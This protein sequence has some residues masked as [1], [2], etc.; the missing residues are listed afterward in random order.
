MHAKKEATPVVGLRNLTVVLISILLTLSAFAQES[1]V[2]GNLA[3]VATDKTGAVVPGVK[4]NISGPTG[5]KSVQTDSQ[6]RFSFPL[7]VPGFYD[8]ATEKAGFRSAQ[9]K[10]LEVLAGRTAEVNVPVEVGVSTEVIEVHADTTAIDTTSSAV[11]SNLTDEFYSKVPISRGVASLFYTAPGVADGGGTGNANPSISGSSG[12]ENQ[13]VAD[14]VNITNSAYGGLGVY[15]QN[16]GA[17]G[18]GITLS[19]IKEVDVKTGGFEPQYGQ[20]TGGI[21]QII[22]K[23]GSEQYHGALSLYGAPTWGRATA[24][25]RDD[26]AVSK[27]GK[28]VDYGQYELSGELGGFVPGLKEH[29]FFFGSFDPSY[30]HNFWNAPPGAGIFGTQEQ[31]T[32]AYDYAGKLTFKIN[33]RHTIEGSVSGDPAHTGTGQLT[34]P[35][36]L[37]VAN[38]TGFSKWDYGTRNTVARYNGTLSNTWLVNA[39]YGYNIN[40]FHEQPLFDVFNIVD[41][42]TP[43]VTT[44]Q[45][46]GRLEQHEADGSRLT[47]DTSKVVSHWGSHTFSVGYQWENPHYDDGQNRS[48]GT[49]TVPDTN[50]M[51][52][53]Y[54]PSSNPPAA[55]AP[56]DAQFQLQQLPMDSSGNIITGCAI[57]PTYAP[58]G[59]AQVV[60]V[61][62]RGQFGGSGL[63]ATRGLYQ[64]AYVN[65]NWTI[66]RRIS[67]SVG[68][69][70]EQQRVTGTLTHYSFTDNWE[71]RL[72]FSIDPWGNKKT[73]IF[74]NFGRYS[75]SLPLDVAIRSLSGEND[76]NNVFFAPV[77][78]ANNSVSVALDSAHVLNGTGGTPTP[79]CPTCT[80][81]FPLPSVSTAS[82][83]ENF[84]P[85]SKLSYEDEYLIGAEHEWHGIVFSGRYIDRRLKRIIEDI[86]GT[87][88]EGSQLIGQNFSIGNPSPSL[89][90]Y[91]NEQQV[92]IPAGTLAP[93]FPTINPACSWS[94]AGGIITTNVIGVD[95]TGKAG[96]VADTNGNVFT[97]N[98]ICFANNTTA[99]L[100]GADGKPDGFAKPKRNYTALEF[101]ANKSFSNG[102]LM[103]FNYRLAKL[104]GNYEGAYRNDNGQSDPG[105]SSLFDFTPGLYNLLGDQ[106][107]PGI[108]STDRLSVFNA[109]FSY[110]FSNSRFK[111]LTIGTS[112]R[113]QSGTPLS[114]LADHPAY[115]NAGEVPLGGRG[116][117]GRSP[118]TGGVDA[119]VDYPV[120]LSERWTLRL[121]ADMFNIFDSRPASIIDQARDLSFQGAGSNLDFLKPGQTNGTGSIPAYQD[122]FY[123]RF[124]VKLEF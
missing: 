96:P 92:V 101:E 85:G 43:N 22:T 72:G 68:W 80:V 28:L 17:I 97:P 6:G 75:Y 123:A 29:L 103:R 83:G 111:G 21:V 37:A 4:V 84:L 42:T 46:F 120:K 100:F 61:Q 13:Y 66:N 88:P 25:Y 79:T 93:S 39:S 27:R 9:V 69:R 113:I 67:V 18:S 47:L 57:C 7:L 24:R 55:G 95:S 70:W 1:T 78:G 8:L 77:I 51:G 115:G 35:A 31:R 12:L 74:G 36:N 106:F 86:S 2:K 91:I 119:K 11:G 5:S 114:T 71:P 20:A 50:F 16:Q 10:H 33:S 81:N 107:K 65:D 26:V 73:K 49:Y 54:L 116:A 117:L 58:L 124:T 94:N 118:V 89:D 60:L 34:P 45:G 98:S 122:P 3:G 64:A 112:A 62:T 87:S 82:L 56:S 109:F 38:N 59:G 104:Y 105:I 108:L 15:T 102:Y 30:T 99:G 40:Y 121:A 90:A 76:L 110:T 52:G 44:L 53:S 19:F 23:S 32:N 48:G 63:R 41:A 14:G